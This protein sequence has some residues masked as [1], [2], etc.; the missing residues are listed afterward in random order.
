MPRFEKYI[1]ETSLPPRPKQTFKALCDFCDKNSTHTY[2]KHEDMPKGYKGPL[3]LASC[4]Y[5]GVLSGVQGA[6][7]KNPKLVGFKIKTPDP[8]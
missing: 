4:D 2:I 7:G 3:P 1:E 6:G 5:C 8:F